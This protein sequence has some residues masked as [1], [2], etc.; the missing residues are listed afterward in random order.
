M[1]HYNR[2]Q[3]VLPPHPKPDSLDRSL[4]FKNNEARLKLIYEGQQLFKE[5]PREP[6]FKKA[7]NR[8]APVRR[9]EDPQT[10]IKYRSNIHHLH[11]REV[12]VSN[13]YKEQERD[14]RAESFHLPLGSDT[15]R[16]RPRPAKDG[17][18]TTRNREEAASGE[19]GEL[20]KI[21]RKSISG[22][23]RKKLK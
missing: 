7:P 5:R 20:F 3:P 14:Q 16:L 4:P 9:S 18:L 23:L 17:P 19:R 8:A 2:R 6:S 11:L 21:K 1:S 15:E 10:D 12:K 22:S 13:R